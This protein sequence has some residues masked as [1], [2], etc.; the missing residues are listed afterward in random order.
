LFT[1]CLKVV[2]DNTNN[3]KTLKRLFFLFLYHKTMSPI[4]PFIVLVLPFLA[5]T[6]ALFYLKAKGQ[7][8]D[9]YNKAPYSMLLLLIASILMASWAAYDLITTKNYSFNGVIQKAVY[10]KP[11]QIPHIT[12]KGK[13]YDL[14]GMNYPDYDTIVAGDIAIKEKGTFEF[15]LIKHK[16]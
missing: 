16:K 8:D 10:E 12:I 5:I 9:K 1:T 4:F 3:G 15:R 11:K 7:L 6:I 13:E 2:G 14:G